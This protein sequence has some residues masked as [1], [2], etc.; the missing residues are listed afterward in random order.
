VNQGQWQGTVV[1]NIWRVSC[2]FGSDMCQHRGWG[3]HRRHLNRVSNAFGRTDSRMNFLGASVP[4]RFA[5][6]DVC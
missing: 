2:L 5:G 1:N 6:A 3:P 4:S